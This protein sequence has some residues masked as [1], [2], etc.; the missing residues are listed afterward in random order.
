MID[1]QAIRDFLTNLAGQDVIVGDDDSLLASK[2]IDSLGV[3]E[4]V[5]FLENHYHVT[6]D[7]DELT[8]DHLDSINAIAGFVESKLAA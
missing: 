1:K 4:L 7:S 6:F 3:A 2:L 8:P 5:V